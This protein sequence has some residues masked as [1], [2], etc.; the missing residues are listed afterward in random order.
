[1]TIAAAIVRRACAVAWIWAALPAAFGIAQDEPANRHQALEGWVQTAVLGAAEAHQAAAAD[2]RFL[3]AISS[4][5][6]ARYDRATGRKD[7]ESRGAAEHLNSGFFWE[8]KLYCAHSNYPKKPEQS[9]IRVL[10]TRSMELTTY[11]DFGQ[12]DGSLTWAVRHA[13]HWWCTFAFYGDQNPKTYLAKFDDAWRELR[14]WRYPPEVVERLAGNSVSG[15]LWWNET[16]LVTGHDAREI[17]RLRLPDQGDRLEYLGTM[18]AP[19][20]GQGIARDPLTGGLVGIDRARRQI[21]IAE[22][23]PVR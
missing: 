15:G 2:E 11:K 7:A 3:Y 22:L 12:S 10:D 14:R 13:D 8:G 18:S 5:A 23:K 19:F 16:L 20:T 4:R 9:E 17:Y 6:I 21:I 1:M